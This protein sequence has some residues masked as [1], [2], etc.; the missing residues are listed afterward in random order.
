VERVSS[1]DSKASLEAF[2]AELLR[3]APTLTQE[4]Q[5]EMLE[6]YSRDES[7]AAAQLPAL[8]LRPSNEAQIACVLRAASRHGI[9]VT[10]RGGGTGRAGGAVPSAGGVV[11]SLAKLN[12]LM[13]IE[14]SSLT[15]CTQPGVVTGEL[16]RAVEEVGLFYPPDPNSLD[17]CHIGGNVATNAGGPRA[18]KYGVTK[19]HVLGLRV[20]LADGTLL[21]TGKHSLKGVTGY[22]LCGLFTGSEGTLGVITEITLRLR[23]KPSSVETALC[24]FPDLQA[25]LG[26]VLALARGGHT[27]RALELLDAAVIE[28][29]RDRC[30][31][32][33][34][35][36]DS[37]ALLIE[38]DGHPAGL[39]EALSEVG[40]LCEA[41]GA[42]TVL[43]AQ[44]ESQ[45]AR[46]WSAR[47]MISH[48]LR[49]AHNFK[50]SEDIAVP[51]AAIPAC[52]DRVREIA[53]QSKLKSAIYGHAGDGN[54]HVNLLYES[55]E[56]S[57][58]VERA[59]RAIFEL[60]VSLGGTLSGEHGIGLLKRPYLSIEQSPA[61]IR[62]QRAIKALFDPAGILNPGK[63]I[64]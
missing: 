58:D 24:F 29:V 36:G 62:Q 44:D 48:A 42:T 1:S 20:V 27:P 9:P 28:A 54:L 32:P 17:S 41:A 39:F 5:L 60:A 57:D 30:E 15:L 22:D 47:R 2:R 37:C 13:R 31:F 34:P 53:A 11:L 50:V 6:S 33:F 43:V 63:K 8:L 16:Q 4:D 52:V 56:Q 38:L 55:S 7:E 14:S 49:A 46:L 26:A 18:F 45:R 40:A 51:L 23:P 25:A 64:L 10:P 61:L 3:E 12:Q 59:M 35:Q 21:E 19:D